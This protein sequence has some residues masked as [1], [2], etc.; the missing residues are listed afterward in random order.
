[1]TKSLVMVGAF[2]KSKSERQGIRSEEKAASK[3]KAKKDG[4]MNRFL[5]FAYSLVVQYS[6]ENL[7]GDLNLG[8]TV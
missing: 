3:K 6:T 5:A 2:R 1:M 8:S 7:D 4:N